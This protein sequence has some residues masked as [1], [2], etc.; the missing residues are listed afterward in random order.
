MAKKKDD[1]RQGNLFGLEQEDTDGFYRMCGGDSEKAKTAMTLFNSYR[2]PTTSA[3]YAAV[4]KDFRNFCLES[5]NL[6]YDIFGAKEVAQFVI[7]AFDSG[8]GKAYLSYIRPAITALEAARE[9]P[10]DK[11]AFTNSKLVRMIG[12]AIRRA[13]EAAPPIEKV[14]E[15]P[16]EAL[17]KG[18]SEHV[19]GK[20]L[21]DI[22]FVT[23][24]TL[25]RWMLGAI[26]LARYEGIRHIQSKDVKV[27][28][29]SRGVRAVQV[30][31]RKEKNDQMH[32]GNYRMLP[33][34]PGEVIEPLTLTLLFF[35]RAGFKLGEGDNYIS[36][37]SQ[38]SSADG[39]FQL[40]YSTAQADGKKLLK[41]LGFNI[42]YGE[43]SARRLGASNARRNNVPMDVIEE[44][45][46]WK[47]KGMVERYLS[48]TVDSKIKQAKALKFK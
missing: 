27:V 22:N 33:E 4:I 5:E 47:T 48:N 13:A 1:P 2:A 39:R 31:L 21:K 43:N 23:F 30:H 8:K 9:T 38:G 16:L 15:L 7:H 42:R 6:R 35:K 34:A 3:N 36:C 25:Y 24:R 20:D 12:G 32:L 28:T 19:W 46:G 17:R 37:R 18:F 44:V 10:S 40:S 41:E 26:T 29:D 45:G 11:S 14:D